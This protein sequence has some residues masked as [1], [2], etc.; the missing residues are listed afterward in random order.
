VIAAADGAL[1]RGILG[2]KRKW[3]ITVFA[4]K[5]IQLGLNLFYMI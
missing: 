2:G 4:Y 1:S 3:G 5:R